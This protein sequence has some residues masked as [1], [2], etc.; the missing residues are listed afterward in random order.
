MNKRTIQVDNDAQALFLE[1][2]KA[3]FQEL[4]KTADEAPDGQVL[5]L[6]EMCA[7]TEGRK[8]IRKA[9]EATV[10]Q[11]AHEVE[12]KGCLPE[13]ANAAE[14]ELIEAINKKRL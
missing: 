10:Q 2:A 6:A 9:L 7:M 8:L 4:M 12:K 3:M 14:Q 11:Q 1:Q 13:R 5:H